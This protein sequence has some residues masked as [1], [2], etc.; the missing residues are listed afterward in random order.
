MRKKRVQILGFGRAAIDC[1]FRIALAALPRVA[2]ALEELYAGKLSTDADL[3]DLTVAV[4]FEYMDFRPPKFGGGT[5]RP[6]SPNRSI[7]PLGERPLRRPGPANFPQ[8]R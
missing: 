4:A 1:S 3:A 7:S 5:K 8:R 2:G 6:I